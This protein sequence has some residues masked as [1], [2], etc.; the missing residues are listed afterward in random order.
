MSPPLIVSLYVFLFIYF[1]KF[2]IKDRTKKYL[3]RHIR[4]P[5]KSIVFQRTRMLVVFLNHYS[6]LIKMR[7]LILQPIGLP[8]IH[9]IINRITYSSTYFLKFIRERCQKMNV[10]LP[11]S[12]GTSPS[13]LFR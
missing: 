4:R 3:I 6:L 8:I 5:N 13:L 9:F 10:V 2:Q 1:F 11:A 12:M 7:R